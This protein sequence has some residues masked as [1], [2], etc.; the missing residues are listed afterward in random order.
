MSLP[1]RAAADGEGNARGPLPR[2]RVGPALVFSVGTIGQRKTGT[3]CYRISAQTRPA[4][5]RRKGL[6]VTVPYRDEGGILCFTVQYWVLG[7]IDQES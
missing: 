1:A 2:R 4:S 5:R 3:E 6:L 7:D